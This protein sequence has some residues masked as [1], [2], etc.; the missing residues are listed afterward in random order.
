MA[1]RWRIIIIEF[2]TSVV[3]AKGGTSQIVVE[4]ETYENIIGNDRIRIKE[5]V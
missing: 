1:I 2:E 4:R 5:L 3:F